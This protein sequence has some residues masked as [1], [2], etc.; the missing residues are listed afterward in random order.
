MPWTLKFPE[1]ITLKD[2]RVI[3]T[4]GQAHALMLAL[5]VRHQVRLHWQYAAELL[6]EAAEYKGS[7]VDAY[8][9]TTRALSA[10]GLL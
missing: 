5:P 8:H 7:V 4:L 10:D 3:E 6:L 2:G 1:P 9:Q